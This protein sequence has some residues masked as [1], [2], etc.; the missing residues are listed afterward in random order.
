ML[1]KTERA[2]GKGNQPNAKKKVK[3][4]EKMLPRMAET[5]KVKKSLTLL[6]KFPNKEKEEIEKRDGY[7]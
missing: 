2:L 4:A 6:K 7:A 5:T 3:I 1:N